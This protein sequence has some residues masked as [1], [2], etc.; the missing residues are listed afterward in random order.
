MEDTSMKIA[1]MPIKKRI[2]KS[3]QRDQGE[4]RPDFEEIDY[5]AEVVNILRAASEAEPIVPPQDTQE[6]FKFLHKQA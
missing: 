5:D 2:K 3:P 4:L 1:A 6:F